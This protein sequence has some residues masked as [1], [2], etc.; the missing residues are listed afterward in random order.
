MSALFP[1][2]S[3]HHSEDSFRTGF[4]KQHKDSGPSNFLFQIARGLG[5]TLSECPFSSKK[6][7]SP[8]DFLNV[9]HFKTLRQKEPE[10]SHIRVFFIKLQRTIRATSRQDPLAPYSK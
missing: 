4:F 9:D 7:M 1:Q 10:T 8:K 5:A 6:R 2:K 3:T